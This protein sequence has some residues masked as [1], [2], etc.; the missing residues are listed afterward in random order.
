M[1]EPIPNTTLT[2]PEVRHVLT[3]L[4]GAAAGLTVSATVLTD[5]IH[6]LLWFPLYVHDATVRKHWPSFSDYQKRLMLATIVLGLEEY[7]A[8]MKEYL[9][10]DALTAPLPAWTSADSQD[11][12]N[13]ADRVAG[14]AD[15]E[16]V[17]TDEPPAEEPATVPA[18]TE[19]SGGEPVP[20]PDATVPE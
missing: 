7:A 4:Q 11:I 8:R 10:A 1:T 15:D 18:T 2:H 19:H 20:D 14:V 5:N 16:G 13:K 17:P 3:E 12:Q 6:M 9:V